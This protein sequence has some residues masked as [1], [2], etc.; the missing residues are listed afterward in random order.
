MNR[1]ELNKSNSFNDFM[2]Y[3][4]WAIKSNEGYSI[5]DFLRE[6]IPQNRRYSDVEVS[7]VHLA[8]DKLKNFGYQI[9][10][11]MQGDI[12]IITIQQL[13]SNNEDMIQKE[14]ED[15]R[16]GVELIAENYEEGEIKEMKIEEIMEMIYNRSSIQIKK[17]RNVPAQ[18][19]TNIMVDNEQIELD[20]GTH[21]MIDKYNSVI[22]IDE[23]EDLK[24]KLDELGIISVMDNIIKL[25]V[26]DS[27]TAEEKTVDVDMSKLFKGYNEFVKYAN[28][29]GIRNNIGN[30]LVKLLYYMG[31]SALSL[32]VTI[33]NSE[34]KNYI[35]KGKEDAIKKEKENLEVKE[36]AL[37]QREKEIVQQTKGKSTSNTTNTKPG[38]VSADTKKALEEVLGK[39]TFTRTV[40]NYGKKEVTSKEEEEPKTEPLKESV[41]VQ[42]SSTI[43]I[44]AF[45]GEQSNTTK[46]INVVDND[47]GAT[48]K[49]KDEFKPSKYR[50]DESIKI[51]GIE[52]KFKKQISDLND[53]KKIEAIKNEFKD[54]D[55]ELIGQELEK[56]E[57]GKTEHI[58]EQLKRYGEYLKFGK[59]DQPLILLFMMIKDQGL[60]EIFKMAYEI[61]KR[62]EE[63]KQEREK[64]QLSKEELEK[65]YKEQ[66]EKIASDTA[67]VSKMR[68]DMMEQVRKEQ[69][70]NKKQQEEIEKRTKELDEREGKVKE[71]ENKNA[72]EQ[73]AIEKDK[74]SNQEKSIELEKTEKD[75]NKVKSEI[76]EQKKQQ[77][78]IK[79]QLEKEQLERSKWQMPVPQSIGQ[80]DIQSIPNVQPYIPMGQPVQ[81]QPVRRYEQRL[82]VHFKSEDEIWKIEKIGVKPDEKKIEMPEKNYKNHVRFFVTMPDPGS[83]DYESCWIKRHSFTQSLIRNKKRNRL[84][85]E[86][87][88]MGEIDKEY[89]IRR[90]RE[91]KMLYGELYGMTV[92]EQ[93]AIQVVMDILSRLQT[94]IPEDMLIY[95][96]NNA[97]LYGDKSVLADKF[98]VPEDLEPWKYNMLYII[99]R[100]DQPEILREQLIDISKSDEIQKKFQAN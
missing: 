67:D 60:S 40:R 54:Y 49:E 74:K 92:N 29:L 61:L 72:Q 88:F 80:P 6:E 8:D 14:L 78:Q 57:K 59:N 33:I 71:E 69:E 32:F 4:K 22:D 3:L 89:E 85:K 97:T 28:E 63:L 66:Q 45:P 53:E 12:N 5:K 7:L 58:N 18:R 55:R 44:N 17:K 93:N 38:K 41:P 70:A 73:I 62:K 84:L 95:I 48:E 36:K 98:N 75:L 19:E 90:E 50:L 25:K 20:P 13:Y 96:I 94:G 82:D 42:S 100:M 2:E 10:V 91:L 11:V 52:L 47:L 31:S 30:Y 83:E 43:S 76:L 37:N 51:L 99:Y 23:E 46:S 16:Q 27:D 86:K 81:T 77:D 34:Y 39:R 1:L 65:M 56:E 9:L 68:D 79:E 64:F 15:I 24:G 87:R 26:I 21:F 35:V